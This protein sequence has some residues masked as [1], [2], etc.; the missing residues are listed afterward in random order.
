MSRPIVAQISDVGIF[1]GEYRYYDNVG[2]VCFMAYLFPCR[3][4][5]PLLLVR[6]TR[7]WREDLST[8]V[9]DPVE[10]LRCLDVYFLSQAF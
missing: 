10:D 8:Y 2:T 6:S 4:Y 7:R 5:A 9:G 1:D 3:F